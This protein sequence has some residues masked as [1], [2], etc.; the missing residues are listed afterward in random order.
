MLALYF[1]TKIPICGKFI[2]FI[3][4]TDIK[5]IEQN[6]E[7]LIIKSAKQ[8]KEPLGAWKSLHIHTWVSPMVFPS[9]NLC[10]FVLEGMCGSSSFVAACSVW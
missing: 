3:V 5:G 2:Y 1:C 7:K 9:S 4:T 8:K 6:D 10:L